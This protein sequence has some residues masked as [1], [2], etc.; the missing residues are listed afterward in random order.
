[1]TRAKQNLTI[2]LNSNFL[3]EITTENLERVHDRNIYSPPTELV[4]HLTHKDV[5]LDYFIGKQY[6]ISQ[7]QSGYEL[8]PDG[9]V[10]LNSKGQ[11]V[12][13]FSKQ[14]AKDIESMKLKGFAL[15][16]VVVNFIVYWKGE[17]SQ[18]EVK[19][20]LPEVHFEKV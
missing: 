16:R 14:F 15:K 5:W 2:H 19:I 8:K 20:I 11:S 6:Y 13:K 4:M 7:L 18:Q 9:D 17:D 12:L 3:D 1:M 10:C